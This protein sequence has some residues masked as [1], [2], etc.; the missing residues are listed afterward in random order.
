MDDVVYEFKTADWGDSLR[1]RVEPG[2]AEY[3][4]GAGGLRVWPVSTSAGLYR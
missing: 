4:A 1:W 2:R 3:D